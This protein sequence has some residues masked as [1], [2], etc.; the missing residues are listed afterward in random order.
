[1][2]SARTAKRMGAELSMIVY[3]RTRQEMPARA[4]EVH[5]AEQ[6]GIRFEL[7]AAPVEVLGNA[8]ALGHRPQM[9]PHAAGRARRL[10]PPQPGADSRTPSSRSTATPSSSPS[11]RRANPLLTA[12]CPDLKLNRWGNIEVDA[13]GMT[14]L[15]GSLRRRR[16]R[17][18]R[19]HR[20][21]GDGRR[22]AHRPRDRRL[23]RLRAVV[24][25]RAGPPAPFHSAPQEAAQPT[26]GEPKVYP[27]GLP[28]KTHL[29]PGGKRRTQGTTGTKK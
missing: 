23:P 24:A 19:G 26:R 1:M 10:R 17:A 15:P 11:A 6:E 4:E 29:F 28:P 20:D 16:H 25:P 5:H 12:T 27:F 14:S 8:A 22:Q 18:R 3:R 7:L 13:E 2:D 9:H 21:P